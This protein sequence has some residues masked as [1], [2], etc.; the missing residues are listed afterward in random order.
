[1]SFRILLAGLAGGVVMFCVG[2]VTHGFFQL[3]S[4][5]LLNIPDSVGFIENL[6]ERALKPGFYI[7]PD[8]PTGQDRYDPEEMAE[9]SK[10]FEMAPTGLLLVARGGNDPMLEMLAKEFVTNFLSALLA[11]W[12]VALVAADVGFGRRWLAVVAIGLIAWLSIAA[13][14]GIWYRFPHDF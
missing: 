3:Q 11:A 1:M 2:F 5:T 4:R 13:S 14:Y 10:R 6:K 8:M 12:V 7:Y 9:A